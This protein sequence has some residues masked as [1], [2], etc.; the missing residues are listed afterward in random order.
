MKELQGQKFTSTFLPGVDLYVSIYSN[1]D[2]D[3]D[4]DYDRAERRRE[5]ER[6]NKKDRILSDIEA[7]KKETK[8]GNNYFFDHTLY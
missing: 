3:D 8:T 2:D 4:Y 7:Y 5:S 6:Q 1:D